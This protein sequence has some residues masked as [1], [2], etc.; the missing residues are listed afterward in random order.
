MH[1]AIADASF[2]FAL[3]GVIPP[4]FGVT[5]AA[6]GVTT[7][8]GGV[9]TSAGG[10]TTAA[11]GATT[12]NGALTGVPRVPSAY[13]C[14][15]AMNVSPG[16]MLGTTTSLALKLTFAPL[17]GAVASG[18][19]VELPILISTWPMPPAELPSKY[20]PDTVTAAPGGAAAGLTLTADGTGTPYVGGAQA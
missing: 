4:V 20:V 6:G 15:T 13:L 12:V 5:P 19:P 7:A 17:S 11:G 16:A 18:G 1:F 8:A 2:L 10:V 3:S 9:T 14:V